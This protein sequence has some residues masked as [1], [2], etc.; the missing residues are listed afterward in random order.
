[1]ENHTHETTSTSEIRPFRFNVPEAE[2]TEFRRT[3]YV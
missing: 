3:G 1:M 2:L